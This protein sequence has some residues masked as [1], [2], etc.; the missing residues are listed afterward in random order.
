MFFISV[1]RIVCPVINLLT[2]ELKKAKKERKRARNN[3]SKYQ[4]VVNDATN[5]VRATENQIKSINNLI[6]QLQNKITT[7]EQE[8]RN[9][10]LQQATVIELKEKISKVDTV[11]SKLQSHTGTSLDAVKTSQAAILIAELNELASF[12]NIFLPLSE[13][14]K[15]FSSTQNCDTS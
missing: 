15:L 12:E 6:Q 3:V 2:R 4:N 14:G 8:I 5:A 10:A 11:L 1:E 13:V 7:H 9:L